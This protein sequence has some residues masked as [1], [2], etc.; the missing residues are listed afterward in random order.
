ME[1]SLSSTCL[2]YQ[3]RSISLPSRLHPHNTTIDLELQKLK[4]WQSSLVSSTVPASGETIRTGLV[5]LA[6]LY[7]GVEE[8]IQSPISQQVLVQHRNG[9]LV[10]EAL[11]GSIGFLD[12]CN[13][14]RD[15]LLMT[16]ENVQDLQSVLRRKGGDLSIE[17]SI[18]AYNS[19]KKKVKKESAK[20]LRALKKM[21]KKY[22]SCSLS[23]ANYYY[24]SHLIRVLREV[25]AAT[26][27]VLRSFF[28]FFLFV[29]DSSTRSVEFA[30]RPIL[31]LL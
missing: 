3:F 19:S 4:T 27:S 8:L 14:A 1:S 31:L 26:I 12:S 9:V 17:R 30:I 7:S 5:G 11:E 29:P 10:E 13:M 25:S 16:K 6:N 23:D 22:D 24:V 20:C 28:F 15:L 18:N 2:Q 21:E